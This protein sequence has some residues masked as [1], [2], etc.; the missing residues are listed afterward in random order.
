MKL[1][2]F[3]K[4]SKIGRELT[5]TV[6]VWTCSYH[7]KS[8]DVFMKMLRNQAFLNVYMNALARHKASVKIL[9]LH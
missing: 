7:S 3:C 6:N 1:T 5:L 9:G 8:S 2:E 4:S